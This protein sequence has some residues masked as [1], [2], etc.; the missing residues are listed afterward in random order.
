MAL[1]E[2]LASPPSFSRLGP[3]TGAAS[4]GRFVLQPVIVWMA[5]DRR[6]MW[7]CHYSRRAAPS[8]GAVCTCREKAERGGTMRRA[9]RHPLGNSHA[10]TCSPQPFW[11]SSPRAPI[12]S[13]PTHPTRG[14]RA[15]APAET[16]TRLALR[17]PHR[18]RRARARAQ[19]RGRAPSGQREVA[20][21]VCCSDP[22]RPDV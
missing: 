15:G 3:R 9:A 11:L 13:P 19:G 1:L 12:F 22:Q 21:V 16:L 2:V 5:R 4:G 7:L 20:R 18:G 14:S 17:L 6:F 10:R 8:V